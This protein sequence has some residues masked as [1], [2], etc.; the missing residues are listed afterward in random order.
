MVNTAI[1]TTMV[2]NTR[3][4]FSVLGQEKV[5][6]FGRIYW[7]LRIVQDD[8]SECGSD[9]EENPSDG[10]DSRVCMGLE[11]ILILLSVAVGLLYWK[12]YKLLCDSIILVNAAKFKVYPV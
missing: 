7:C 12:S 1:V 3:I 2:E 11:K 5:H 6:Q 10:I 9:G 4:L 8:T